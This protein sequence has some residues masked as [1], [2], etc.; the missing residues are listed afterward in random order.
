[1]G[2]NDCKKCKCIISRYTID[3]ESNGIVKNYKFKLCWGCGYFTVYPNIV[4]EF[5]NL[6]MRDQTIIIELIE[7][8]LLK[9]IL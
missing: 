9:P 6:I 5:T 2:Y 1:M 7:D 8:K 3:R 4:D